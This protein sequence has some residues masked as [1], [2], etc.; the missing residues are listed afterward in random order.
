M[1]SDN[2]EKS[3]QNDSEKD[4]AL[5][6]KLTDLALSVFKVRSDEQKWQQILQSAPTDVITFL[7]QHPEIMAGILQASDEDAVRKLISQFN[8]SVEDPVPES[9]DITITQQEKNQAAPDPS[10]ERETDREDTASTDEP[11]AEV[12]NEDNQKEVVDTNDESATQVEP[13]VADKV[14]SEQTDKESA[15]LTNNEDL[16]VKSEA[17]ASVSE[18]TAPE[19]IAEDKACSDETLIE[20]LKKV[21]AQ[22]NEPEGLGAILAKA[23]DGILTRLDQ[24]PF[25]VSEVMQMN[26]ENSFNDFINQLQ[27]TPG[28]VDLLE[29][30]DDDEAIGEEVVSELLDNWAYINFD[31]EMTNL[32]NKQV[33]ESEL[34]Q[35]IMSWMSSVGVPVVCVPHEDGKVVTV[36]MSMHGMLEG[37]IPV[38]GDGSASPEEA[39]DEAYASPA[40]RR[41]VAAFDLVDYV[42]LF[43]MDGIKI[44][45]GHRN[46]LRNFWAICKLNNIQCAGFEPSPAEL[47]WYQKREGVLQEKFTISQDHEVSHA[48]GLSPTSGGMASS[49]PVE[50]EKSESTS[51]VKMAEPPKDAASS[52]TNQDDGVSANAK[53]DSGPESVETSGHPDIIDEHT[54][55]DAAGTLSDNAESAKSQ[56]ADPEKNAADKDDKGK[57]TKKKAK[58]PTKSKN[59]KARSKKDGQKDAT[60]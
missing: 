1:E 24:N 56:Q 57:T 28:P 12:G 3:G 47:M 25:Y 52:N 34:D 30:V 39:Y 10:L 13:A 33:K 27:S 40:T 23:D 38:I 60:D 35:D 21:Y 48:P 51:E 44:R 2:Q 15:D 36:A 32:N 9:D 54:T 45:S 59:T 46:L 14:I 20:F 19:S 4:G 26:N 55:D 22:K 8:Q 50:L 41:M 6:T 31:C 58:T 7:S 49:R 16:D 5:L 42:K 11:Q 37:S 17:I 43:E 18:P 53:S 29:S